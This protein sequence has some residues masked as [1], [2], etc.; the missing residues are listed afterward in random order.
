M[1]LGVLVAVL[2]GASA[3]AAIDNQY[4]V[5]GETITQQEQICDKE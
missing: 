2:I 3:G 4:P 1:F 5:V